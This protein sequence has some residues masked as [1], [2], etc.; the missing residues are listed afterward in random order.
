MDTYFQLFDLES[1]NL[2]AD[3]A[4][5]NEAWEALRSLEPDELLR[6]GLLRMDDDLVRR[7]HGNVVP[8]A[9][10]EPIRRNAQ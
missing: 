6:L 3:F 1:G 8:F 5:E 10:P 9:A 2:I 7:A 4:E